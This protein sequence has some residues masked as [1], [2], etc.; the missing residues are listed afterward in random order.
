VRGLKA[1]LEKSSEQVWRKVKDNI[2]N[3]DSSM[4]GSASLDKIYRNLIDFTPVRLNNITQKAN[5][6]EV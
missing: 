6:N 3:L 4:S 5:R 2:G 1:I